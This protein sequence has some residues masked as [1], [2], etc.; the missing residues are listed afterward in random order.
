MRNVYNKNIDEEEFC[1]RCKQSLYASNHYMNNFNGN[2]NSM[3]INCSN[4]DNRLNNT[5]QL[6]PNDD[7][8]L[9][10]NNSTLISQRDIDNF[11][12]Q[13]STYH[14]EEYN[15]THQ[16]QTETRKPV[17][18]SFSPLEFTSSLSLDYINNIKS[19]YDK[20]KENLEEKILELSKELDDTRTKYNNEL[21]SLHN[22]LLNHENKSKAEIDS[23]KN[24]HSS[25]LK[26]LIAEKDNQ[27]SMLVNKN[28]DLTHYNEELLSKLDSY[29]NTI[30]KSKMA[31]S[32]RVSNSQSEAEHLMNEFKRTKDYYE[33]KVAFCNS[34]K[35]NEKNKLIYSYDN[36]IE[37]LKQEAHQ[38]KERLQKIIEDKDSELKKA[39]DTIKKE[40]EQ[41]VDYNSEYQKQFDKLS[42]E[43]ALLLKSNKDLQENIDKLVNDMKMA[44][45]ETRAVLSEKLKYEGQSDQLMRENNNLKIY[46]DKLNRLTHGKI[47][48]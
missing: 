21:C 32:A 3:C 5:R 19:M 4:I 36:Q 11:S 25:T 46:N 10:S 16:N 15:K 1:H 47:K 8:Y 39:H 12:K 9:F 20:D 24:D 33:K 41:F 13:N 7:Y 45:K 22:G 44:K 43:R 30:N 28:N 2:S 37:Q 26:K 18:R 42:E 17:L 34:E 23:L 27:I 38:E 40:Q 29:L 6:K 35:E 48:K 31:L 14:Q